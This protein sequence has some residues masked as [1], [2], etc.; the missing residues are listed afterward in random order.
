MARTVTQGRRP[1]TLAQ[2][3]SN[4]AYRA[5]R[6]SS[7]RCSP[8]LSP[9]C[10][11]ITEPHGRGLAQARQNRVPSLTTPTSLIKHCAAAERIW[12]QRTEDPAAA[13]LVGVRGFSHGTCIAGVSG[14]LRQ[15]PLADDDLA[16]T[17]RVT[18]WR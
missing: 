18:S 11:P 3:S 10:S 13:A 7:K 1:T 15:R 6:C 4:P 17:V 14:F 8:E 16:W 12:F 2:R 9:R 5:R